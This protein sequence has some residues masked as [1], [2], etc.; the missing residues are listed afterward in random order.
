M[1][2][3]IVEQRFLSTTHNAGVADS[4]TVIYQYVVKKVTNSVT[5]HILDA[6]TKDELDVFC[7]S[8]DWEV[9]IK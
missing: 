6:L 5:P 8:E 2:T 1:K 9:T 4:F 7:E 3:L